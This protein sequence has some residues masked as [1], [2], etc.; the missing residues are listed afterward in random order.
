MKTLTHQEF[1]DAC[2]AQGVEK[3]DYLFKCPACG[4]LQS[5]RD[6][7]AAGVGPVEASY[8]IAFSC[9]GRFTGQGSPYRRKKKADKNKGCNFTL[10]GLGSLA[11]VEIGGRNGGTYPSFELA[12]PQEAQAHAAIHRNELKQETA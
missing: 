6:L 2:D 11:P 10:A 7:M 4:T 8:H 9:V 12:T 3:E 1:K 5:Q